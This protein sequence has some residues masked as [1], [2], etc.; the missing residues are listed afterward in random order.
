L[1][2]TAQSYGL[3]PTRK[4]P[5]PVHHLLFALAPI[6]FLYS[7][8]AAKLP[9]APS[10]L[11]LPLAL[12]FAAAL[13]LWLLLWL[14]MHSSRRAALIVSIILVLFF[15]YGRAQNAV[16][17]ETSRLLLPA[18]AAAVL[19]VGILLFGLTAREFR[20]LTVFLNLV[21]LALVLI[22]SITLVPALLRSESSRRNRSGVV[23]PSALG[24]PDIYYIILDSYARDD[25]L[26]QDYGYDNSGFT[27][28][29]RSQGFLVGSRSRSNYAQTYLSLASSLNMT[30]LDSVAERAGTASDDRSP[31]VEM[32][33]HSRVE[34]FLKQHGY[35]FVSFASGYTGTEFED[36]DVHCAPQWALSEFQN[37]LLSTTAL[38]AILQLTARRSQWDA[39]RQLI[40]YALERLPDVARMRPPVFAFCHIIAPHPPF[41][42]GPHGEKLNPSAVFTLN[43][44]DAVPVINKQTLR[45]DFIKSYRD[46]LEFVT[47]KVTQAVDRIIARSSRPP[48]IILQGDH[49][50]ASFRNWDDLAPD[51]LVGRM[52]ILNAYLI[53]KDSTGPAWY[54]SISPVNTFR[55]IFDRVFGDSLPLLPD[56]SWFSTFRQ[57]YRFYDI[58]HPEAYE[59][60]RSRRNAPL[61][62]LVFAAAGTPRPA[63]IDRY[64]RSLVRLR[65]PGA[66]RGVS[67]AY[68]RRLPPDSLTVPVAEQ[69]YRSAVASG[70]LPDLGQEPDSYSGPGPDR[71]PVVALFFA[72][73]E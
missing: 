23:R 34:R 4:R 11:L 45:Q 5:F 52:S 25:I 29:L 46:Q 20:G 37:V 47:S 15:N 40:L 60:A 32:I 65:Y 55:L 73:G 59:R 38:P 56:R 70:D 9:I 10:E 7:H 72:N 49:G 44:A 27:N 69:A 12:S 48:I 24:L 71:G 14:V 13:V 26:S 58:D 54:D 57:P 66:D 17:P 19:L 1:H 67:G 18:V 41:V 8:N 33:A 51:Q 50:P 35:T 36:A 61:S 64:A 16:R 30:Y 3:R 28:H 68:L 43:D 53:P 42:F 2:R 6:L 62:V 21:S 63:D 22:N 31:L 39:Q